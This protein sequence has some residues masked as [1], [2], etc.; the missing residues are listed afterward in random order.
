MYVYYAVQKSWWSGSPDRIAANIIT[1]IGFV[2]AG[3]ILKKKTEY[4]DLQLL[5][6]YGY[7]LLWG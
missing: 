3:V 6:R 4:P 2:G 7:A 5:L 1:G